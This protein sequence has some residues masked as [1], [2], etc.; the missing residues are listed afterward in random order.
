M[1]KYNNGKIYMIKCNKTNL[2]YVGSTIQPLKT[3]L[4]KHETDFRGFMG[5]N[6]NKPRN[7]RGS[8][9]I[10]INGDY[11][12]ELLEECCC[13]NRRELERKESLY[14]FKMSALYEMTNKNMPYKIGYKDLEDIKNL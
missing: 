7:Y 9:D 1:N 5:I 2:C 11:N 4:K 14:I 13:E 8:A 12:I 6:G 10:I 3:R